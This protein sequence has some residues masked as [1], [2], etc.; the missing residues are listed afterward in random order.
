MPTDITFTHV[1][2]P[3]KI[4][5]FLGNAIRNNADPA[6]IAALRAELRIAKAYAAVTIDPPLTDAE[7]EVIADLLRG[8]RTASTTD[9]AGATG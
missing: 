5:N 2:A 1:R 7:I 9:T 6:K 8:A 4:R 3:W